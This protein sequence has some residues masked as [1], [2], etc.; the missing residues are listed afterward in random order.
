MEGRQQDR[1]LV[2][3][4]FGQ[5]IKLQS[6]EFYWQNQQEKVLG[7]PEWPR[8]KNWVES[9]GRVG[10]DPDSAAIPESSC[11]AFWIVPKSPAT[12]GIS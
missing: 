3:Q 6:F 12:N 7:L 10:N 4:Y 11:D 9:L 5:P 8:L 1:A 2:E